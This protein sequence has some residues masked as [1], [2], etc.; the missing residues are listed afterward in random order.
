MDDENVFYISPTLEGMP[1][2]IGAIVYD[3]PVI[4]H[5]LLSNIVINRTS[6]IMSLYFTPRNKVKG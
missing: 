5:T 3:Y 6:E 1:I 4:G 2:G